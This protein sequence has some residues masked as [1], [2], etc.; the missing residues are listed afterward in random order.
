MKKSS[1]IIFKE[2]EILNINIQQKQ[3]FTTK[4]EKRKFNL[5]MYAWR[6]PARKMYDLLRVC[7]I[8]SNIKEIQM[9][10]I[11]NTGGKRILD[12]GCYTGNSISY[13]M[14]RNADYYLGLDLS[15]TAIVEL[16]NN[17]ISRGF[18]NANAK[19]MDILSE[20]FKEK[21]FD[22][23]YAQGVVHHFKYIEVI[24]Q[25]LHSILK[26]NGIVVTGD[27]LMTA[28]SSIIVRKIYHKFRTDKNW[29][30]PFTKKTIKTIQQY[31]R[32]E[33]VQ[34]FM[35]LAKWAIPLAI[36]SEKKAVKLARKLHKRDLEKANT[37]G[38]YVC[39]CLQIVMRL[40][41]REVRQ[42]PF[43]V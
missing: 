20:E 29:E 24:L 5:A 28:T 1:N 38:P 34:G 31:F 3:F 9:N 36:F 25:K 15:E 12:F 43:S 40:K 26:P 22:I 35:G 17:L 39:K 8:D 11:G 19:A 16:K 23:I 30:Y 41:K 10:W 21:D 2:E 42:T 6:Y 4:P 18:E 27:P 37:L 14:A 13:K 7:N 33:K 32:I